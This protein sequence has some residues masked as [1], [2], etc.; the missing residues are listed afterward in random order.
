MNRQER[1]VIDLIYKTVNDLHRIVP[2]N[3]Y[4]IDRLSRLAQESDLKLKR[5]MN[6]ISAIRCKDLGIAKDILEY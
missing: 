1:E 6:A 4:D 3:P 5:I 2:T